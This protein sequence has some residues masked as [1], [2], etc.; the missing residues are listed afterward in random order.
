MSLFKATYKLLDGTPG[1]G[2]ITGP[3]NAPV[4]ACEKI[5]KLCASNYGVDPDT[6]VVEAKEERLCKGFIHP[7]EAR[8]DNGRTA[9][10]RGWYF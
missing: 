4:E 9:E 8:L 10:V 1:Q 7:M 6:L 5:L 3:P 2:T